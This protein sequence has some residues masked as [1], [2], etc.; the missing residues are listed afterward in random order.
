MPYI[1]FL[2]I[3]CCT[4]Y[5][6]LSSLSM[7]FLFIHGFPYHMLSLP[8]VVLL[9]LYCPPCSVSLHDL[10]FPPYFVFSSLCGVVLLT[11]YF[12]P[13]AL[14]FSL[15]CVFLFNSCC[16]PCPLLFSPGVVFF[17]TLCCP[18]HTVFLRTLYCPYQVSSFLHCVVFLILCCSYLVLSSS[19]VLSSLL[20]RSVLTMLP[21][22]IWSNHQEPG[23]AAP[24]CQPHCS[25]WQQANSLTTHHQ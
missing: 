16:P 13:F 18:P 24:L 9:A 6:W 5:P 8:C 11:L 15:P 23:S 10:C 3:L 14:L 1:V 12:P 19:P 2:H 25:S 20:P 21:P 17:T 4:P 22:R 7:V